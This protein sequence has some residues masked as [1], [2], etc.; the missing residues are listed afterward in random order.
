M[1]TRVHTAAG[2]NSL[3]VCVTRWI[4]GA[5]R[6]VLA[7][8]Q[9]FTFSESAEGAGSP[10]PAAGRRATWAGTGGAAGGEK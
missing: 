4:I 2:H 5:W 8:R 6:R 9:P 7:E 10:N 1:A 3:A